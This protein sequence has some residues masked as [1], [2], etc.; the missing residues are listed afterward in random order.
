M[1]NPKTINPPIIK[2]IVHPP[3]SSRFFNK[4][5]DTKV[6]SE[7]QTGFCNDASKKEEKR[8]YPNWSYLIIASFSLSFQRGNIKTGESIVPLERRCQ[9][10]GELQRCQ[11][12]NYHMQRRELSDR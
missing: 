2:S 7:A 12:Q 5:P 10:I 9:R 11:E 4:E 8:V 6:L 1:S 3:T